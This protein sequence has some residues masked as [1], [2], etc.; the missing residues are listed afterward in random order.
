MINTSG[1]KMSER[2]PID[3]FDELSSPIRFILY[4]KKHPKANITE[5][6]KGT[7][8]GQR[9]LYTSKEF[10]KQNDL[11]DITVKTTI[12]YGPQYTLSEKGKKVADLLEELQ[13]ILNL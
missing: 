10:C 2:P 6:I 7:T 11:L 13:R 3:V 1:I 9:A 4:I 12:P 8:A 5:I